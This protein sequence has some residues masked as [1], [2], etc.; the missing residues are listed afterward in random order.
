MYPFC[1]SRAER[2]PTLLLPVCACKFRSC[3]QLV[4]WGCG[5]AIGEVPP[6][7]L[8][9]KAAHAGRRNVMYEN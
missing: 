4:S 8:S 1:D 2:W 6:Y 7:F 3:C 9:Y 5:T